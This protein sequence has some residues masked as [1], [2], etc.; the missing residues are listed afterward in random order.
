[1]DKQLNELV[2]KVKALRF[3][4]GKTEE[5]M[6]KQ[7][8]QASERQRESIDNV[9]KAIINLKETIEEKKFS[10]GESEEDV[11]EWAKEYEDDLA[12]ADENVRRLAQQIK[13]IDRR[14]QHEKAVQDHKKNLEFER[15][16]LEQKAEFEK[17]REKEKASEA[18]NSE[19]CKQNSAAKSLVCAQTVPS[20]PW[21]KDYSLRPIV[22]NAV[23]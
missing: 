2:S 21:W 17:E 10:K 7:D 22:T 19:Q 9:T 12:I 1:M 5:I 15:E 23:Q 14:E 11:A 6:A 4:Q 8:R 20:P 13:E 18:E 3:R 16:L